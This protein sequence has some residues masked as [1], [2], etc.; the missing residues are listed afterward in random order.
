LFSV[1]PNVESDDDDDG[2]SHD[3]SAAVPIT[4]HQQPPLCG[5]EG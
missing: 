3:C 2:T 4:V 5:N 1:L